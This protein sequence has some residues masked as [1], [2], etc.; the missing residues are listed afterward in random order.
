M[1]TIDGDM[2]EGGGQI[3]RTALTLSLCFRQPF[4]IV[5]IRARRKRPGLQPQHLVAVSAAAA[6]GRADVRGAELD[7]R[8]ILFEPR[9]LNPGEYHF[10]IGTAGSTSL[11]LQTL[12]PALLTAKAASRLT[13]LGGTHNPLAPTYEYLQYAYLPLLRRMGARVTARLE[14]A[15]FYPAGGGSM[16]VEVEPVTRLQP[17]TLPE[18]GEIQGLTAHALLAHLPQH[19][20]QRELQVLQNGLQIDSARLHTQHLDNAVSPGNA[21]ILVIESEHCNEV[22][23]AIGRRGLRAETVAQQVVDSAR[24]YLNAGVPVGQ[25]LADQLLL[26]LV[27]AGGGCYRTLAP[28]SHTLTNIDVIRSFVDTKIACEQIDTLRWELVVK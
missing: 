22:I 18:R 9:Q 10:D 19:I 5:H 2:G 28:D 27:L 21:L 24:H 15:G 7:S 26:P 20:A 25:H 12:L 23:S 3:L 17:L 14:R 6:I 4:R 11:V 13:L 1:L 16:S 8:E